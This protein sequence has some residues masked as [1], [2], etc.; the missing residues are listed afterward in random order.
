VSWAGRHR[1]RLLFCQTFLLD[2]DDN[3]DNDCH[4][5]KLLHVL[6]AGRASQVHRVHCA[7]QYAP[8]VCMRIERCIRAAFKR[9]PAAFA[10]HLSRH[11]S[12]HLD[13]LS[14]HILDRLASRCS[15]RLNLDQ[16]C[17][18]GRRINTPDERD[19]FLWQSNKRRIEANNPLAAARAINW[20][21]NKKQGGKTWPQRRQRFDKSNSNSNGHHQ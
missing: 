7:G 5:T 2:N 14:P 20:P 12:R 13:N 3:D 10:H 11:P 15:V 21:S 4:S 18:R 17:W 19:S 6:P 16:T 9:I 8:G 1:R